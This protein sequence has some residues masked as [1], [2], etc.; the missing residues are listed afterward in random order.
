MFIHPSGI[1]HR[2]EMY[3]DETQR[4]L[5]VIYLF[6]ILDLTGRLERISFRFHC[7]FAVSLTHIHKQTHANTSLNRAKCGTASAD[8]SSNN[9]FK[10]CL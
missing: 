4:S 6:C 5:K 7:S 3:V 2:T 9:Y 8:H 1:S 10:A